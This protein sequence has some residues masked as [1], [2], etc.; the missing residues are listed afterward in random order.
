MSKSA[1]GAAAADRS[2]TSAAAGDA[3]SGPSSPSQ[4]TMAAPTPTAVVEDGGSHLSAGLP[5]QASAL[6]PAQEH[7]SSIQAAVRSLVVVRG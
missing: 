3:K 4:T 2:A 7:P 5:M 1:R 6:L